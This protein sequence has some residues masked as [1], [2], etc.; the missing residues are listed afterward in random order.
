MFTEQIFV[1]STSAG[2]DQRMLVLAYVYLGKFDLAVITAERSK[3]NINLIRMELHETFQTAINRAGA[4]PENLDGIQFID[5]E[6]IPDESIRV[7]L[8]SIS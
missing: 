1:S 8:Y 5:F 3:A 2:K 6:I 7:K 4:V